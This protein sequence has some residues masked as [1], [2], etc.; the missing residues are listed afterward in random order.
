MKEI[1]LEG[2]Y[3]LAGLVSLI[4]GYMALKDRE[5]PTRIGTALFWGILAVIFIIGKYLPPSV[6]GFMLLI[7]GVLT[8]FKQVRLGSLKNA[9]EKFR[10]EKSRLIGNKIFIPALTIAVFAFGIAQFTK[11]GGL[12]GLGFGAIAATII[13][14][15]MTK[16]EI[17]YIGYDGSRL[18]QQVGSASILPQLLA[19]LGALFNA[20]GVGQVIAQGISSIIPEGNV[21]AGV[22]AYCVGMAIFTMIMGNAFAAFAVITAG[23]G[24]P[25]VFSQGANPAIAGALALTAGYCGT[26]MTP[27]AANFNI[28]PAAILETKN[29]NRIILSQIPLALALLVTHIVLMYILAF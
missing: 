3:V 14:L 21:L 1:L 26:L 16:A 24:L 20:A 22:I 10:K 4:T 18:L 17:K 25:F 11:L 12:V 7:M 19:A 23:I 29:K 9:D 13:A 27:M 5:L 28:V 8:A 6:V 15:V 2:L